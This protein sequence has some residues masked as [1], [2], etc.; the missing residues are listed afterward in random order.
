MGSVLQQTDDTIRNNKIKSALNR[1]WRRSARNE[2]IN[3]HL[4]WQN[5]FPFGADKLSCQKS[6][7]ISIELQF[8]CALY[9]SQNADN[10]LVFQLKLHWV[11]GVMLA[12]PVVKIED[13]VKWNKLK[14]SK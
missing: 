9:A 6:F 1:S 7:V 3:C 5:S 10:E 12:A 13:D 2:L 11:F 8:Q 14:M 4:R